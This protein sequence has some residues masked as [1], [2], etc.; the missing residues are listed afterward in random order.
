MI[1]V[2]PMSAIERAIDL[3]QPS[4]MISLLDPATMVDTP[5][6]I[7]LDNHL[8]VGVNDIAEHQEG[9]TAPDVH[10]VQGVI[11]FAAAWPREAPILIHC[12]AG[13]SRSTASAFITLCL[14]NERGVESELAQRIRDAAPHAQPNRRIVALADE[15]MERDGAM[16]EAVERIGPGDI[17]DSEGY[18]FGIPVDS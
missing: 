15:I 14:H 9:L 3:H 6:R 12:W 7:H 18:L 4:H 17:R 13:I 5:D 10:H 8:K 11:D 2:C 1:Y 16:I